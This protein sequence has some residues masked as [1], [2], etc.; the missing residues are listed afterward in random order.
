MLTHRK[1]VL[2]LY[3]E[4]GSQQWVVLDPEG[5]FWIVPSGDG[6]WETAGRFTRPRRRT[7]SRSRGITSTCS[8]Y[9]SS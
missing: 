2:G 8:V 6:S 1:Q 7:L 5:S 3:V 4:I 9:R